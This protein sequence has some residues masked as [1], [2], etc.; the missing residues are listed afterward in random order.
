M[1]LGVPE[2]CIIGFIAVL[3]FGSGRIA[4]L[5]K[6]LGQGIRHFK[7]GLSEREHLDSVAPT[8]LPLETIS[9]DLQQGMPRHV[10][11]NRS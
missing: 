11:S 5:G 8:A 9:S 10:A 4:D 2:L 7:R 6:G 3:M 1:G